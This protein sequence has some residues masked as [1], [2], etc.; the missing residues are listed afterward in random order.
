MVPLGVDIG[1]DLTPARAGIRARAGSICLWEMLHWSKLEAENGVV[2]TTAEY[3]F[4]T[5]FTQPCV[6]TGAW[7]MFFLSASPG[8][9]IFLLL[10]GVDGRINDCQCCSPFDRVQQPIGISGHKAGEEP[11]RWERAS[12]TATNHLMLLTKASQLSGPRSG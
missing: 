1:L 7:R 9:M 5:H 4:W 2:P 12:Q 8:G 6:M 3:V 10:G 11:F